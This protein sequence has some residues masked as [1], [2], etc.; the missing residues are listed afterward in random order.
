MSEYDYR[1]NNNIIIKEYFAAY[2]E[3][4]LRCIDLLRMHTQ[5]YKIYIKSTPPD[6]CFPRTQ[7]LEFILFMP[8][9]LNTHWVS[10]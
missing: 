3:H 1:G 7:S 8:H 6:M 5:N 9:C 10:C 2:I 4:V